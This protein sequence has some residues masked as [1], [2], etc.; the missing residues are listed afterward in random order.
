[1]GQSH[2]AQNKKHEAQKNKISAKFCDTNLLRKKSANGFLKIMCF[3]DAI[4]LF[5]VLL[6][7]DENQIAS[8]ASK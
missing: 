3:S 2:S 1:M 6:H 8:S 5:G 7:A 4:W